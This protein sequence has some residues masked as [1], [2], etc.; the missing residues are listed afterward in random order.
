MNEKQQA[1]L[2]L[3]LSSATIDNDFTPDSDAVIALK[4]SEAGIQS[5][6]TSVERWRKQFDFKK[7]LELHVSAVLS[8]DEKIKS[9]V[10]KAGN[11]ALIDK[12]VVDLKRNNALTSKSYEILEKYADGVLE[13][14]EK[15]NT[16]TQKD[17]ELAIKI[18]SLTAGR[19]DRML[20]R[21]AMLG[22]AELISKKDALAGLECVDVEIEGEEGLE[23]E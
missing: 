11:D 10:A 12:T 13:R 17:A 7:H 14:Y 5:S 2:K 18:A 3:Y 21:K 1:A 23:L 15:T 19:E 6:K 8:D 22:A 16:I 20:D 9:M 4:M